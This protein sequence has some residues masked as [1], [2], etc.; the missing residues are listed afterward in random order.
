MT[1]PIGMFFGTVL[2]GNAVVDAG[3]IAASG[4][5]AH[6]FLAAG[7]VQFSFQALGFYDLSARQLASTLEEL[8]TRYQRGKISPQNFKAYVAEIL[9]ANA[10]LYE[11]GAL[12]ANP[13]GWRRFAEKPD[14][15]VIL[16]PR[17]RPEKT[18]S[19][20]GGSSGGNGGPSATILSLLRKRQ[21]DYILSVTSLLMQLQE[22]FPLPDNSQHPGHKAR[23][24]LHTLTNRLAAYTRE[25]LS[26]KSSAEMASLVEEV[27]N[28]ICNPNIQIFLEGR[29]FP[30][31]TPPPDN[32]LR[33][34]AT[35]QKEK[36]L[37]LFAQRWR[38]D[39]K[40]K[41]AL[42]HLFAE[43]LGRDVR[44]RLDKMAAAI[45]SAARI[46]KLL[47]YYIEANLPLPRMTLNAKNDLVEALGDAKRA[48]MAE[49]LLAVMAKGNSNISLSQIFS[50]DADEQAL[51]TDATPILVWD[52]ADT[53]PKTVWALQER[54]KK[55]ERNVRLGT[56][57]PPLLIMSGKHLS[58]TISNLFFSRH[59][60]GAIIT[61]VEGKFTHYHPEP[62]PAPV[63]QR[64]P[65]RLISLSPETLYGRRWGLEGE[66]KRHLEEF[67]RGAESDIL[68]KALLFLDQQRQTSIPAVSLFLQYYAILS[69]DEKINSYG[70]KELLEALARQDDFEKIRT[71]TAIF[72]SHI[73]QLTLA[74][75]PTPEEPA[76]S[77]GETAP[78]EW[79]IA[80]NTESVYVWKGGR[81]T[82]TRF[83]YLVTQ[84]LSG[85]KK[86]VEEGSRKALVFVV[87]A[88]GI[89]PGARQA[90][91]EKNPN[92]TLLLWTPAVWT[93][94]PE[95]HLTRYQMTDEGEI[96][97][98]ED[99]PTFF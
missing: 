67:C 90:F 74:A 1:P 29:T 8:L 63:P 50:P 62:S 93:T 23:L 36:A 91:F 28:Q 41:G 57:K 78:V 39:E 18:L 88:K 54:L 46:R 5:A 56:R 58:E 97:V 95:D 76:G 77:F 38:L 14:F 68:V 19:M 26:G 71:I 9:R 49:T 96:I 44:D 2:T 52:A 81:E 21:I 30:L 32:I 7:E 11:R 70:K 40:E 37:T 94:S 34:T 43:R 4:T 25:A 89:E 35:D 53:S 42:E 51:E 60:Q 83:P 75:I 65:A 99:S 24:L 6:S 66:A 45:P 3:L 98:R 16:R 82:V 92:S 17:L 20:G 10:R 86:M 22:D 12:L 87:I 48:D 31:W 55:T 61:I 47:Q 27:S 33:T 79:A 15:N 85:A 73:L 59:P 64:P 72:A 13:K 84:T 80:A 69:R